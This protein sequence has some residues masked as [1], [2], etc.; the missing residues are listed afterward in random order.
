MASRMLPAARLWNAPARL[1]SRSINFTSTARHFIRGTVS[2]P[3]PAVNTMKMDEVIKSKDAMIKEK[4]ERHKELIKE[5]D[6]RLKEKDER[7][8]EK[9]ER[10]KEFIEFHKKIEALHIESQSA[11]KQ[12]VTQINTNLLRVQGNLHLRSVLSRPL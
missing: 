8:K 1:P 6:E 5:K 7:L 9:D 12:K 11:M 3:S 4:D 10:L 2:E